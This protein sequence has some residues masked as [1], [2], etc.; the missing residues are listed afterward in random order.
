LLHIMAVHDEQAACLNWINP[1]SFGLVPINSPTFTPFVG[2]TGN[3]VDAYLSIDSFNPND[4]P[5]NQEGS[6]SLTAAVIAGATAEDAI[7]APEIAGGRYWLTPR[8]SG[9]NF[10]TR[11]RDDASVNLGSVPSRTG[12]FTASRTSNNTVQGY[13][14]GSPIGNSVTNNE[15]GEGSSP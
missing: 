5:N 7:I 1:E 2:Y 14:D 10:N 13:K 3:G 4:A 9:G 6:V 12:I 8:T 11:L 15:E